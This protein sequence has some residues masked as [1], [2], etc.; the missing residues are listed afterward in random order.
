MTEKAGPGH[1][2]SFREAK[3]DDLEAIVRLLAADSLGSGRE[4]LGGEAIAGAY[5]QAFDAIAADPNNQIIVG[6]LGGRAV[7]CLQLTLIPG[8]TYTG[9][10]RAQI[11]GVRVDGSLRGEGVG[12]ALIAH[13]IGLARERGCALV[14]LTTDKR[15]PE[16]LA[17]YE[18][19]GFAASHEG[20]KLRLR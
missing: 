3:R 8:L 19:L 6:D 18:A 12:R 17:F 14:Q 15:R 1:D 9:G 11:E 16:A 7:A 13:A 5:A 20:M 10:T 2:L 4:S